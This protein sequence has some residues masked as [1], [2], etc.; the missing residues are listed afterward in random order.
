MR[1]HS[2]RRYLIARQRVCCPSMIGCILFSEEEAIGLV[3][4]T[5]LVLLILSQRNNEENHHQLIRILFFRFEYKMLS[6]FNLETSR[7]CYRSL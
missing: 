4:L 5:H 1:D 6:S 3:M 7:I 2:T